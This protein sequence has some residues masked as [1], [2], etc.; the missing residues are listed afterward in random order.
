MGRVDGLPVKPIIDWKRDTISSPAVDGSVT[1]GS[2]EYYR[3]VFIQTVLMIVKR[4]APDFEE[5]SLEVRISKKNTY[6]SLTCTIRAI[7]RV[8][9]DALY[10]ELCGHPMVVMVL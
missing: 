5:A 7:S 4:H 9:L 1:A 8:Q 2:T 3:Q 10:K 6:L